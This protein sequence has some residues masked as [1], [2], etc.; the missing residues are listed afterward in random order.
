M[1]HKVLQN[2]A[3]Y[4]LR[5]VVEKTVAFFLVPVFTAYMAPEDFG[6]VSLMALF[7]S[8]GS[9]IFMAGLPNAIM[10]FSFEYRDRN[11]H[12]VITANILYLLIVPFLVVLFLTTFGEFLFRCCL[13][14]VQFWPFGFLSLLTAYFTG[15]PQYI[16]AYWRAQEKL[17]EYLTFSLGMS[18]F[19]TALVLVFV[20]LCKW[21]AYGKILGGTVATG[22][23]C[24]VG[25]AF[26]A[27][28]F[29]PRVSFEKLKQTLFFGVPL[30]PHHLAMALLSLFDRYML[31]R[32][33][34]LSQVGIYSLGYSFG[35]VGLFASAGF[36][37]AWGPY[38]YAI[39]SKP[40]SPPFVS[41]IATYFLYGCG[42][43]TFAL[44][45]CSREIVALLA[46]DSYQAAYQVIP[47]VALGILFHCIYCIP[48]YT[49]YYFKRTSL[50]P[51]LTGSAAAL[52]VVL[53]Y[54]F[55]PVW[56]IVGAAWATSVSYAAMLAVVLVVSQKLLYIP[57]E[58]AR[59]GLFSAG[60]GGLV[61]FDARFFS[62][63]MPALDGKSVMIKVLE[64]LLSLGIII[65][66]ERLW[67]RPSMN[68]SE[69]VNEGEA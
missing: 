57:Y 24:L 27:R 44:T 13:G 17:K 36:G 38:F 49:L 19:N 4:S 12:E 61:C 32:L 56:G 42:V 40:D 1:M 5:D 52:N 31:E 51:I 6:I 3:L 29:V 9:F 25:L 33:S 65:V 11:L 15:I 55:I 34:D 46:A 48:V 41:K 66:T 35:S 8:C 7:V 21:G 43:I 18:F 22:V 28:E 26:L 54:I 14:S 64:I 62:G 37:Q 20:V 45:I 60:L 16:L 67:K 2:S 59:I 23:F 69:L 10:R 53:N 30:V 47:I 39:A 50:I 63:T 58:W 68:N